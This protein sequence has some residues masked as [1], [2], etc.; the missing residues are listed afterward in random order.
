MT[1]I[2]LYI[3]KVKLSFYPPCEVKYGLQNGVSTILLRKKK[4]ISVCKKKRTN[5]RKAIE[6]RSG[7]SVKHFYK[8]LE[9]Q[10]KQKSA[11]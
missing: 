1:R 2:K 7:K 11:K 4:S 3:F 9:I 10:N 8:E 5:K 6:K